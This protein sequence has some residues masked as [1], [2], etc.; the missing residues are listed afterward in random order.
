MQKEKKEYFMPKTLAL[1]AEELEKA[2]SYLPLWQ[3][4]LQAKTLEKSWQFESFQQALRFINTVAALAEQYDHH[5]RIT[6][7]YRHV[8]LLLTTHAC[9]NLSQ[10]D[11]D[12][13]QAIECIEAQ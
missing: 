3:L 8:S 9:N 2:M 4:N 6:S 10:R 12:L 13:A 1:P 7:D 5:P 11:I